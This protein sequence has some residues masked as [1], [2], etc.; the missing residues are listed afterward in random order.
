MKNASKAVCGLLSAVSVA[1]ALSCGA[2]F[3]IDEVL[4]N[5][6]MAPSAKLSQKISGCNTSH[7]G[8]YLAKNLQWVEDYG[9]ERHFI[10][11]DRGER[12]TGFLMKAKENSDVYVFGAHGYRSYGKKEFCGVAQYYLS[13]GINVFFPDHVA[14]GES[15]GSHC[16][17]G[18]YEVIDSMKWLTYM[19]ET[20]GKDIKIILHGVSMGCATV[21]MMSGKAELSRNVKAI[22]ADCGFSTVTD[23]FDSKLKDLGIK[24]GALIKAVN[25]VNKINLG[26]DFEELRPVD[27]VK[28]ARVPMIFIHGEKDA[29]VPCRMVY[30]LFDACGSEHKELLVIK[31]ADHAQSFMVGKEE[32]TQKLGGF[33]DSSL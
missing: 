11:S 12:L 29:L 8:D 22:V 20:F 30:E 4:F 17:F 23:L 7:L 24:G 2:C 27:S 1:G 15:E 26:F 33:I 6:K 18:H 19:T 10:I 16:T 5:R 13:K 25:T 3:L 9:Y 31:E 28:N 14:S 32:Y 21:T